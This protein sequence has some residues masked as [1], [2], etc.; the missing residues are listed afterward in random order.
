MYNRLMAGEVLVK[1]EEAKR[2][3]VNEKS[4]QRD[5]KDIRAHFA[6]DSDSGKSLVYDWSRKGYIIRSSRAGRPESYTKTRERVLN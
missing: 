2:F 5:I 6:G 4:I 1:A 3:K